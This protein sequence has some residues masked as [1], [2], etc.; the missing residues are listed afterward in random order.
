[1]KHGI[2]TAIRAG[3]DDELGSVGSRVNA[4][5]Q[6]HSS[7]V[8]IDLGNLL[9]LLDSHGPRDHVKDPDQYCKAGF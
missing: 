4:H 8:L 2:I 6:A 3:V 1:M 7:S 9:V 5:G